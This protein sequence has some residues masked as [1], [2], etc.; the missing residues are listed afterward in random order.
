M[1]PNREASWTLK[2][3]GPHKKPEQ[4]AL[5]QSR[6]PR[7]AKLMALAIKLDEQ[8]RKNVFRDYAEISRLGYISRARLTQ[9]MNLLNLAPEIQEKLL[10]DPSATATEHNMRRICALVKWSDQRMAA[11]ELRLFKPPAHD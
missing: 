10:F 8:V 1:T 4:Q 6:V 2:A 11:A 7:I 9:I 5:Q 3:R